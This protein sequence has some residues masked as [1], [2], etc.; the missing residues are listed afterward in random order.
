MP[1]E[2]RRLEHGRIYAVKSSHFSYGVWDSERGGFVGIKF[3][4]S[5][6]RLH[7]DYDVR[8]GG[9]AVAIS[10]TE[11]TMHPAAPLW[12]YLGFA[13]AAHGVDVYAA[14]KQWVH[15]DGGDVC[16]GGVNVL[17]NVDL[18]TELRKAEQ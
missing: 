5:G 18:M 15:M 1:I 10:E 4:A 13:C 7:L 11:H 9:S 16:D 6:E 17:L 3:G 2:T 12:E 8:F 14:N